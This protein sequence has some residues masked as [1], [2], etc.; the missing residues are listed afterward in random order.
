MNVR[1][2]L[3]ALCLLL[4][5]G[6]VI[7]APDCAS[8]GAPTD[9]V[10]TVD[11]GAGRP[12]F[13]KDTL[14]RMT[15]EEQISDAEGPAPTVSNLPTLHAWTSNGAPVTILTF[16][17]TASD[18]RLVRRESTLGQ[19]SARGVREAEILVQ[20]VSAGG[21]EKRQVALSNPLVVIDN[22]DLGAIRE[23]A[24]SVRLP[25]L[26]PGDQVVVSVQNGP[27]EGLTVAFR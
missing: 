2:L 15:V 27:G 19:P 5:S 3:L 12:V 22:P 4:V 24:F 1:N 25:A 21:E 7:S 18:I 9:I 8:C 14:S 6:C 26:L 13:I 11:R 17:M 23:S 20:V 10:D 16:E